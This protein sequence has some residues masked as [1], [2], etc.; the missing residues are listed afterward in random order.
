MAPSSHLREAWTLQH[1][2]SGSIKTNVLIVRIFHDRHQDNIC[3]NTILNVLRLMRASLLPTG[4]IIEA[5]G[6]V[7]IRTN[8]VPDQ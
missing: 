6:R 2:R 8:T 5:I 3:E 7:S 4:D 1:I